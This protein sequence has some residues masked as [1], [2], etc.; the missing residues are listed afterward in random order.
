MN[1]A[2]AE[3]VRLEVSHRNGLSGVGTPDAAL[4][5]RALSSFSPLQQKILA[6]HVVG[7]F[8]S[9]ASRQIWSEDLCGL[10]PGCG[11]PEDKRHRFLECPCH[12][13]V[14]V[15]HP[16]AVRALSDTYP[17]W[18]HCPYAV[19][20]DQVDILTLI[21]QTRPAPS[22]PDS[23][24][25]LL[26]AEGRTQLRLYTDGT[27]AS[28][29]VPHAR[30]AGWAV[31]CD[32]AS[33][34]VSRASAMQ[35]WRSDRLQPAYFSVRAQGLVP[36]RQTIARAE[37]CAALQ[38]IRLARQ[39]CLP[40]CVVSDSSYVVRV[41]QGFGKGRTSK[42]F[43]RAANLDLILL[44]EA[45]WFPGVTVCKVKSHVA[46]ADAAKAG[47]TCLWDILGNRAADEACKVA[48]QGDISVVH[49]LAEDARAE[50]Q[51]QF[52]ALRQVFAYLLDLHAAQ[53]QLQPRQNQG[54][55]QTLSPSLDCPALQEC[56]PAVLRWTTLRTR[57][58][59]GPPLPPPALSVLLDSPWGAGFTWMVW[60]WSQMVIWYTDT[61]GPASGTTALEL[62]CHF[63]VTTGELPPVRVEGADGPSRLV[64]WRAHAASL[65]PATL[66][67][68][69]H[70]LTRAVQYLE[71]ACHLVLIPGRRHNKI[72]SLLPLGGR[73][74][75]AGTTGRA[76]F[77]S[78]AAVLPVL[79]EVT[80]TCSA[81]T[82]LQFARRQSTH[83][84]A[85][86]FV[87]A[88]VPA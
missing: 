49:E 60:H 18:V 36:G 88:N 13:L 57:V 62:L 51:T 29:A 63:V 72:G 86:P 54:G 37:L 10:C 81:A 43:S 65:M 79:L 73:H 27:C 22:S 2:W 58:W 77:A 70:A 31:V 71:K 26:K 68:W 8:Q 80:R 25:I 87:T 21:F 28:P 15:R 16:D 41:L 52:L 9:G 30:H 19:V 46:D 12:D 1:R 23:E 44:L 17:H 59:V 55:S 53:M 78:P 56:S 38:A 20:P 82:L 66:R 74:A 67:Y 84:E 4:T 40:V 33:S 76:T 47:E 32:D 64:H 85:P 35:M 5:F 75:R 45:A 83:W 7:A 6:R 3:R 24:A 48:R 42:D 11:Q 61:P 50:S 39:A 34:D 69:I 14:R